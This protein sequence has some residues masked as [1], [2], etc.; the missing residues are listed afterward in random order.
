[1]A[2]NTEPQP[3]RLA[4]RLSSAEHRDDRLIMRWDVEADLADEYDDVQNRDVLGSL[5]LTVFKDSEAWRRME[6]Q[7]HGNGLWP[8]SVVTFSVDGE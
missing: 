8:R 2:T 6:V 5:R 3:V 7:C 4:M 1:M